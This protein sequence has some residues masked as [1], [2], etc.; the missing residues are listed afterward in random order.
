[1]KSTFFSLLTV[2]IGT[3]STAQQ[4]INFHKD[5]SLKSILDKAK[6]EDKIVFM[7]AYATWCGPCKML[8]K[9][10]FSDPAIQDYF[11][12]EFLNL[13]M[14]MEKG[15]GPNTG[16]MYQVYSYPTMLFLDK[17]GK[18]IQRLVGYIDPVRL[19]SEAQKIK[20][21]SQGIAVY[22]NEFL[23]GKKDP[24]FLMKM[25]EEVQNTDAEIYREVAEVYFK[26]KQTPLTREEFFHLI[27][28]I[29][30][31][32]D[33]LYDYFKKNR[34]EIISLIPSRDYYNLDLQFRLGDIPSESFKAGF[35]PE[36]EAKFFSEAEKVV[37]RQE[38]KEY[39]AKIKM[40]Y[41]ASQKD[42]INFEK[43]ATAYY[44]DQDLPQIEEVVG[45]A[46]SYVQV[47]EDP[48]VLKNAVKIIHK[49]PA[50]QNSTDALL[51]LANIYKKIGNK[52][53]LKNV[54]NKGIEI[55]AGNPDI[56]KKFEDYLLLD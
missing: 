25:M 5:T 4:G 1:M 53:D 24:A 35:S 29:K 43:T 47:S 41:F 17:D 50:W 19:L 31:A 52:V 30:R 38:A 49:N 10:T 12:K 13:K 42:F 21:K 18:V 11:N 39:L 56:K 6:K 40:Q 33:P 55:S 36:T 27:R 20:N 51:V 34:A 28:N 44:L 46:S 16:R 45:I 14:D 8:D 9:N 26:N 2:C 32:D 7:D 48:N 23:K 37:S 22:K 54:L 3:F 15:E